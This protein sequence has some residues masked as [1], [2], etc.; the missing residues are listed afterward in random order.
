M[1]ARPTTTK[2]RVDRTLPAG[3]PHRLESPEPA[4]RDE[5]EADLVER[6]RAYLP[7]ADALIISDYGK[8]TVTKFVAAESIKA[9]ARCSDPDRH[10]LQRRALQPLPRAP[11]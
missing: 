8:G 11:P 6:I 2:T 7:A 3:R 9:A 5:G 4:C 1:P 10:R